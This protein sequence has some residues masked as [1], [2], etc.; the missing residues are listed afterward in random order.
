MFSV[1]YTHS[2]PNIRL[3]LNSIKCM[4]SIE[5]LRVSCRVEK[6][7]G[8]REA[9]RAYVFCVFNRIDGAYFVYLCIAY[10][11]NDG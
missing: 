9:T 8:R 1:L 4:E 7:D 5:T 10:K 11:I 6:S 3:R 2:I